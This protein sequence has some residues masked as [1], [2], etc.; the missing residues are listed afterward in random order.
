MLDAKINRIQDLC[1]GKVEVEFQ[2]AL[3]KVIE[4][5]NDPAFAKGAARKIRIDITMKPAALAADKTVDVLVD[6]HTTMPK[7]A[8][9]RTIAWIG[10]TND[11][12]AA[13]FNDDPDQVK[14]FT[15]LRP[16]FSCAP[17][18]EAQA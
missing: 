2:Q 11:G 8:T 16:G 12:Q 10:K 13:L 3:E 6:V 14:M 5:I 15:D 9:K 1:G 7:R 18:P 17:A 4:N